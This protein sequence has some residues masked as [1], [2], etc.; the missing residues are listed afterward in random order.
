LED[1]GHAD[2]K[3]LTGIQGR[4]IRRFQSIER[5]STI[6]MCESTALEEQFVSIAAALD[7]EAANQYDFLAHNKAIVNNPAQIRLTAQGQLIHSYRQNKSSKNPR[8]FKQ[9]YQT[10]LGFKNTMQR[11]NM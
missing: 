9:F 1:Q 5:S 3:F 4:T 2:S 6:P 8:N 10:Q 11:D 7:N